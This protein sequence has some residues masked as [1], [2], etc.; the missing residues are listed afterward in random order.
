M[1]RLDAIIS[2][3]SNL[4]I[5]QVLTK[6]LDQLGRPQRQQTVVVHQ[7]SKLIAF[8]EFPRAFFEAVGNRSPEQIRNYRLFRVSSSSFDGFDD[9][10]WLKSSGN[11]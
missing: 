8:D 10:R 4:S 6:K 11:G 3:A 9:L 1:R 2:R 7:N 5:N